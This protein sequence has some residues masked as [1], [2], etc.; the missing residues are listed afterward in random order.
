MLPLLPFSVWAARSVRWGVLAAFALAGVWLR[1]PDTPPLLPP[2]YVS[3]FVMLLPVLWTI[4]WWLAARLPGLRELRRDPHRRLWAL[5]L[6]LLAL[7]A[8]ASQLWAFQRGPH[9][10]VGATAALQF[11]LVALFALACACAGPPHR[12]ILAVLA[13]MLAAHALIAG[14]QVANQRWLGLAALGEFRVTLESPG[15]SVVQA[16][17]ARWLR[18]YG[19]MPHP[20]MLAGALL[21]G[22]L[23]AAALALNSSR[24]LRWLGIALTTVGLYAL[25]LTFSRAAWLGLAAGG[26]ALA[27]GVWRAGALRRA[28]P[29]ALSLLAA[30]TLF[31]A[32]YWPFVLARAG[33][34]GETTE[35]RSVA[36]RVVYTQ[37]A[38]QA[39]SEFPLAGVGIGNFPWRASYYLMFVGFDLRGDN[40]HNV[41]LS[42]WA[43]LGT[44]GLG[45]LAVALAAGTW[46]AVRAQP[47]VER[48]ALL[49]GFAALS[50]VGLFDHY[51]WTI[52][53][54]Q[55]AWWGLL[56]LA[57][58]PAVTRETA[59][60]RAAL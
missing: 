52:L 57:G 43:E 58:A 25:L 55:V 51:P 38:L 7:W 19:L 42:A 26:L 13:L 60:Q 54:F 23:A 47:T 56:A 12:H 29:L 34:G 24:W 49:A 35:Q 28:L 22:T 16:G 1:L 53:H 59:K 48:A 11:G 44:V 32:L 10:E 5:A 18:P 17:D 30:G 50:V 37:F 27:A 46:A 3:R 2:L 21:L 8:F 39:I 41:Y 36:D 45:L 15:V 20:N 14:A 40:V 9:P 4:G 6:L 31:A 33:T